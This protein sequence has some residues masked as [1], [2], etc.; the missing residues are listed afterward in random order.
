[1][2]GHDP[3]TLTGKP[4]ADL[5]A[6]TDRRRLAGA[7]EQCRTLSSVWL[8]LVFM[9]ADGRPEP[10]LCCFQRL[11]GG[12]FPRGG[13]VVTGLRLGLLREEMRAESASILGQ[14]AFRCHR[15]AHRL[16]QAVEAILAENPQSE[17]AQRC[18]TELDALLEAVGQSTIWPQEL[19]TDRPV[20]VVRILRGAIK[21]VEQDPLFEQFK[22]TLRPDCSSAWSNI[23]PEGLVFVALHL[24]ANAHEAAASTEAPRLL[25]D[26]NLDG[27]RLDIEFQDNGPGLDRDHLQ[28]VFAPCFTTHGGDGHAGMG[29]ATCHELVRFM[30]G[31]MRMRS[32]PNHGTTVTVTLPAAAAPQ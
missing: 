8:E 6:P 17:V 11:V 14:L 5:V 16:M 23:P 10:M 15:P 13:I 28:C 9:T 31:K 12:D 7:F 32:S 25:I 20:D 18:R 29:L 30:G 24:V 21:L 27:D 26:V 22:V 1:V 4:L 2:L 3:T 19:R